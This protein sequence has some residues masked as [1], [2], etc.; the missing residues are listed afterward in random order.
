VSKTPRP[1]QQVLIS[2]LSTLDVEMDWFE[3]HAGERQLDLNAPTHPTCRRYTDYFIASAYSQPF[4]VL[5]AITYG[6]EVS[7]LCAWSALEASG[8]YAEFIERWSNAQFVDYV[9]QLLNSCRRH[10]HDGQQRAFNEVLGH[11]REFWQ[12]T[13]QG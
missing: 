8:P 6:V 7:Y 11:E 1:A 9:G 13:W 2:G 10:P 3:K 5:L 12:M 4:E